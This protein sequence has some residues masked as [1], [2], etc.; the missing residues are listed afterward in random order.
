[1]S[2]HLKL[3][4]IAVNTLFINSEILLANISDQISEN[5]FVFFLHLKFVFKTPLKLG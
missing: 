4:L 3:S 5:S 2:C 1:M